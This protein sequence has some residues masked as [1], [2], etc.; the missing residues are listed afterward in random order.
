P[1]RGGGLAL[2]DKLYVRIRRKGQRE[3]YAHI[4]NIGLRGKV[5]LLTAFAPAGVVL[6]SNEPEFVLGRRADGALLGLNLSWPQGMPR[7]TFPRVDEIVVIVTSTR[8]SLRSLETVEQ[9]VT[10][11]G[12]G[13]KLEAML[14]QLQDGLTRNMRGAESIDGFLLKRLMYLLH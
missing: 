3:L 9:L 1:E 7:E 8:T 2:R 10:M 14:A 12:A 11:R 13:S 4:F 6:N 5:T